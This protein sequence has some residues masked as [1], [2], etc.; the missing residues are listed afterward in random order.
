MEKR[1]FFGRTLSLGNL[2]IVLLLTLTW[3]VLSESISLQTAAS[4]IA[5]S[6][7]SMLIFRRFLPLPST[8]KLNPIR[9][10]VYLFYLFGHMYISAI[11]AIM[12]IFKKSEYGIIKLKT[13]ISNHFLQTML[14]N[15]ITFTPGTISLDLED[16]VITVLLLRDSSQSREESL[17]S[18]EAAKCSLEKLLLKAE[19]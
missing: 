16:N 2:C 15:S 19:K 13:Q 6:I 8:L 5:I 17:K 10:I 3:I 18:A 9:F 1:F 4:G 7:L 11:K 12:L 14:A